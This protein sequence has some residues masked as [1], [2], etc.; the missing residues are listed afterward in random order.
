MTTPQGPD[1]PQERGF[2]ELET[3]ALAYRIGKEPM[4]VEEQEQF[5]EELDELVTKEQFLQLVTEVDE[6]KLA[7]ANFKS[8]VDDSFTELKSLILSSA[9]GSLPSTSQ[10]SPSPLPSVSGETLRSHPSVFKDLKPPTFNGEEK[11]RNA[12]IL[13]TFLSK[14]KNIHDLKQTPDH[15]QAIEASLSLG[16]MAYKWWLN[17]QETG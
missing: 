9:K 17:L 15:L 2:D 8:S 7:L 5:A 12:D 6:L 11:D 10:L 16:P 4:E 1:Q 13:Q 3:E 14:W